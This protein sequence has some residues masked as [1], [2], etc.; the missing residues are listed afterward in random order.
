VAGVIFLGTLKGILVAVLVSLLA[1]VIRANGYPLLVLGRKPG[2][3]IFRP[4]SDEHPN[5]ETIPGMLLLRPEGAIYFVNAPRLGQ[6][7]RTLIHE[8]TPKVVVLDLSAVPNL[9]F[10][11]LRML[12]N[13]EE[14][15][16]EEGVLLWLVALNP[17][18]LTV[19]R[20]SPLWE[21]LGRER[22]FFTL[23]EAVEKYKSEYGSSSLFTGKGALL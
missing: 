22:L 8:F 20:N 18:V 23:E 7:I 16:R 12:T 21:R 1:I 19:V 14:K 3:N 9:E 15:Q 4:R 2:T 17:D 11:A 13:G 5:D 10:T 6:E